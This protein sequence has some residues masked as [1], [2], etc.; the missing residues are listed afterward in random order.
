MSATELD[1]QVVEVL[2]RQAETG[3]PAVDTQTPAE[4]RA[5]FE[6]TAQALFGEVDEL[7]S[8]GDLDANGVPVRVYRPEAPA[9]PG[10]GLVYFHGGGW[11][12]GSVE[13]HDGITRALAKRAGCVVVSVD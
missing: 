3:T 8:V 12:V 6:R 5:T 10:L 4:A 7:A 11:V 1:P 13:T 2:R 9:E